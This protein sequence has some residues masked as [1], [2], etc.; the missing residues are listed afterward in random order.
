M[1]KM[2]DTLDFGVSFIIKF[3]EGVLHMVN[4]CGL[5]YFFHTEKCFFLENILIFSL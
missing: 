1:E 2:F 5:S 4:M 3:N